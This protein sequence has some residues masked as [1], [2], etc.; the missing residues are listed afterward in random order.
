MGEKVIFVHFQL[1]IQ[2][3]SLTSFVEYEFQSITIKL[4]KLFLIFDIITLMVVAMEE[5]RV[6]E[7]LSLVQES[8]SVLRHLYPY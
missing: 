8:Q 5:K 4:A 7:L 6:D 3:L 1:E 2:Q